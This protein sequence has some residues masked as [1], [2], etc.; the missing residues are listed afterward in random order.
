ML[1]A[2][3]VGRHGLLGRRRQIAF[4][5]QSGLD[6][7]GVGRLREIVDRAHLDRRNRR[8]DVAVARQH[9]HLG[10]VPPGVYRLGDVEPAAVLQPEVEQR[11]GGRAPFDGDHPFGHRRGD[12]AVEAARFHDAG[13][14]GPE[15][16]VVVDD[17][18]RPVAARRARRRVPVA[19]A[20]VAAPS[21]GAVR[22]RRAGA[23][24]AAV[25]RV[26]AFEDLGFMSARFRSARVFRGHLNFSLRELLSD[27][28]LRS[29]RS[30]RRFH[31]PRRR[32]GPASPFGRSSL[33]PC[34]FNHRSFSLLTS[35]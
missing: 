1:P 32:R 30:G 31:P 14:P 9:D 27:F 35:R 19:H 16:R 8:G 15:R 33:L 13:E 7:I 4:G 6:R 10:G 34:L 25:R 24:V 26:G 2:D 23:D 12:F 29:G 17:Q 21:R 3:T 22:N 18:Q 20:V 5:E 28:S 11:I